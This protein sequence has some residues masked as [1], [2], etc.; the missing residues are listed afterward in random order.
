MSHHR[1]LGHIGQLHF[2]LQR[3][4]SKRREMADQLRIPGLLACSSKLLPGALKEERLSLPRSLPS[5][6]LPMSLGSTSLGKLRIATQSP[7]LFKHAESQQTTQ[8]ILVHIAW[9]ADEL[10]RAS[11]EK[12]NLSQAAFDSVSLLMA[13]LCFSS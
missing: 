3:Y 8:Q 12:V 9:L 2:T 5:L 1:V 10:F 11:E 7:T 6:T 13:L 4:I